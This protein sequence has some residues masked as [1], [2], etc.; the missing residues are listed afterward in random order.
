LRVVDEP[1]SEVG[2]VAFEGEMVSAAMDPAIKARDKK[3]RR[4]L[5][6]VDAAMITETEKR[7]KRWEELWS[8]AFPPSH[9]QMF[10]MEVVDRKELKSESEKKVVVR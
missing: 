6:T 9:I 8:L 10:V 3:A 7:K 1:L 5:A 2:R 4:L